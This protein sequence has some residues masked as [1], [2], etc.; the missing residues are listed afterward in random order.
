MERGQN[1]IKCDNKQIGLVWFC[2][3]ASGE[4]RITVLDGVYV[5]IVVTLSEDCLNKS[6]LVQC[7]VHLYASDCDTSSIVFRSVWSTIAR[8][9]E[10]KLLLVYRDPRNRGSEL[11]SDDQGRNLRESQTVML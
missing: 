11:L 3:I 5:E 10:S 8:V 6:K 7:G 1:D 4:K 2:G 9:N